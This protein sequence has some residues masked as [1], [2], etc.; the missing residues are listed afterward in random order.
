MV[1]DMT[2]EGQ[3]WLRSSLD[4]GYLEISSLPSRSKIILVLVRALLY[5]SLCFVED[6]KRMAAEQQQ[7]ERIDASPQG[8]WTPLLLVLV[9]LL[10]R[11]LFYSTS[12]VPVRFRR[13]YK[14]QVSDSITRVTSLALP[15]CFLL[16]VYLCLNVFFYVSPPSALGLFAI[17]LPSTRK[18]DTTIPMQAHIL[19]MQTM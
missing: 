10:L 1:T 4:S 17:E 16:P 5:G 3:T 15:Y 2:V 18:H 8:S 7:H 11:W 9:L 19:R 6:W 14:R 12:N 13:F